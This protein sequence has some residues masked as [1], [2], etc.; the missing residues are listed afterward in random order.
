MKKGTY[1]ISVLNKYS[2]RFKFSFEGKELNGIISAN[3][4][5]GFTTDNSGNPLPKRQMSL[6]WD[7]NGI[8]KIYDIDKL[9]SLITGS[10]KNDVKRFVL[11]IYEIHNNRHK[12]KADE[13]I[14]N[15][16]TNE[17]EDDIYSDEF[18]DKVAGEEFLKYKFQGWD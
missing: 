2:L 15:F 12:L 18:D 13:R 6:V 14:I 10:A 9:I 5:K 4:L 3:R 16:E 17:E 8:V 7:I 11:S 1:N